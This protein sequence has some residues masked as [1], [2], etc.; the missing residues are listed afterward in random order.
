MNQIPKQYPGYLDGPTLA[1]AS[2]TELPSQPVH[3]D[4]ATAILGTQ[5]QQ[6]KAAQAPPVVNS[7]AP[8][9]ITRRSLGGGI[10]QFRVQFIAPTPA[11]DPH[12]QM[13]SI[14]VAS[15]SGTVRL[16]AASGA[17]PII[18]NSGQTTAPASIV[19]Q[20]SNSNGTSDT[21]MG[22]G[23]SRALVQL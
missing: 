19:L 21:G 10:F 7:A 22:T 18:F 3:L 2:L 13:T 16:A 6:L 4:L 20:Q 15:P 1:I 23:N 17:G 11:Q 14:L 12:Y 8:V 9:T 5:I